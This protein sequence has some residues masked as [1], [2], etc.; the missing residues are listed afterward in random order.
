MICGVSGSVG[1]RL[2]LSNVDAI[3]D[4]PQPVVLAVEMDVG[5][6]GAL[7]LATLFMEHDCAASIAQGLRVDKGFVHVREDVCFCGLTWE[8]C[9]W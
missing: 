8:V 3:S 4:G 5:A 6:V 7:D 9:E 2:R 1:A